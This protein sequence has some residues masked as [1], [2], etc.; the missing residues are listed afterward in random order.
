MKK[1]PQ[2]IIILGAG[3]AG[4]YAYLELHKIFHRQPGAIEITLVSNKDFFLFVPMIHEVATGTLTPAS[5]IQPIR[6]I[7]QCC[8]KRFV[9]AQVE[10]VDLDKQQVQIKT[11]P[12]P[13]DATH[14]AQSIHTL[15]YDY[16]IMGL[17]S[18]ANFFN[19]PGAKE[20]GLVL[21]NLKDA[22]HIKNR[23]IRNFERAQYETEDEQKSLLTF[24]IIGGGATGVEL[25]GEIADLISHE[26]NKA[27]PK[28][29]PQAR[30]IILQSSNKLVQ[31]ADE[32]FAR[33]AKA[34]LERKKNVIIRCGVR[35][36][37]VASEGVYIGDE[38]IRTHAA[39]W[40]AGV[41]ANRVDIKANKTIKRDSRTERL[42]VNDFLQLPDY[43][44]TFVAG[45]QTYVIDKEAQQPYPMRAQ[46]AVKQGQISAQNIKQLITQQPLKEF[47]WQDKGIIL[48]LGKGGALAQAK[49][50]KFS[51]PLAWWIYRTIYLSKL[52]GTRMKLRTALEW[53]VN[54]FTSRDISKL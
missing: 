38:F 15:K 12:K 14:D 22:K 3:F 26:L 53:T 51:G 5:I 43:H 17:G 50:L 20:F 8:L 47:H 6:T 27:F 36:T 48:S 24:V 28:L 18:T 11:L 21:K 13:V 39:I 40:T 42:V 41:K 44:H 35:V 1:R 33:Q 52:I 30:V 10:S 2:H 54:L 37:R 4:L 16:L 9:Q 32:W 49:G 7:P 45:D 25:A 34:I 46:F 31:H 19:I 23:I 29:A